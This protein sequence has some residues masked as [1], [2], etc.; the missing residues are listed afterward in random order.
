MQ[1]FGVLLSLF[2]LGDPGDEFSQIVTAANGDVLIA[3]SLL[4]DEGVSNELDDEQEWMQADT[5][6]ARL[7]SDAK[8]VVWEKSYGWIKDD[9]ARAIGEYPD[10]TIQVVGH[11]WSTGN[12]LADAYFLLLDSAGDLIWEQDFGGT[13]VDAMESLTFLQ[14]S[15]VAVGM[16]ASSNGTMQGLPWAMRVRHD[17]QPIWSVVVSDQDSGRF[18]D[19]VRARGGVV[20][21]GEVEVSE[22]FEATDSAVTHVLVAKFSENGKLLWQKQHLVGVYPEANAVVATSDGGFVIAGSTQKNIG[23]SRDGFLLKLTNLGAI[24]WLKLYGGLSHDLFNDVVRLPGNE[25]LA[26][27][28][29]SGPAFNN[30]WVR[31]VTGKGVSLLDSSFSTQGEP[32][33][34]RSL[35]RLQNGTI[36]FVGGHLLGRFV[37]K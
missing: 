27:G 4:V 12:G 20:A 13:G 28:A 33:Y 3:G 25:L 24:S 22:D 5:Y 19:V 2:N 15:V 17:G 9:H 35:T 1:W 8:T 21:V 7:K 6:I 26:V 11:T 37:V 18:R 30:I 31:A 16:S 29:S 14:D 10:G 34:G 36:A 23:S 32:V